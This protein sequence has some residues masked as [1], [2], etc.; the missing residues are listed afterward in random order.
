MLQE[1]GSNLRKQGFWSINRVQ[2]LLRVKN[3]FLAILI[4][5]LVVWMRISL[6]PRDRLRETMWYVILYLGLN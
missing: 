3:I 2:N 4:L 5:E 6:E 1:L